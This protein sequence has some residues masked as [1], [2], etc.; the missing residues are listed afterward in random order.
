M[1]TENRERRQRNETGKTALSR[2]R[3]FGAR[4]SRLIRSI[5]NS[6]L[7]ACLILLACMFASKVR[8]EPA[9]E[10]QQRPECPAVRTDVVWPMEWQG[11]S[12][13]QA[14]RQLD[15]DKTEA[16]LKTGA[17]VRETDNRGTPPILLALRRFAWEPPGGK[18]RRGMTKQQ[19][20]RESKKQIGM[21]KLLLSHGADPNQAEEGG[22]TPLQRAVT[23]DFFSARDSELILSTLLKKG[24]DLDAK[25]DWGV[26]ALMLAAQYNRIEIVRFLL[27]R[28]ANPKLVDCQGETALSK[29]KAV[30]KNKW[31]KEQA[32]KTSNN[33]IFILEKNMH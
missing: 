7:A 9:P 26:T 18:M 17:D 14:V 21:L 29:A 16:L 28:G 15:I 24:A 33:I 31:T 22:E 23:Q 11:S 27:G 8:A 32:R 19:L 30:E 1:E 13:L 12:F 3:R 25:D 6:V 10:T 4:H 20:R 5:R 2:Q